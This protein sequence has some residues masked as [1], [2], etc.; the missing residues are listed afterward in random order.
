MCGIHPEPKGQPD[1][2][3]GLCV[4][5]TIAGVYFPLVVLPPPAH[6][7]ISALL[8]HPVALSPDKDLP[9]N[10]IFC[11]TEECGQHTTILQ[12]IVPFHHDANNVILISHAIT[13]GTSTTYILL[14]ALPMPAIIGNPPREVRVPLYVHRKTATDGL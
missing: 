4:A 11:T 1:R 13:I 2:L 14:L 7:F 10:G 6:G 8:L 9:G 3:C 5:N 12:Q